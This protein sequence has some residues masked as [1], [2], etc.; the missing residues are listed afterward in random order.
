MEIIGKVRY[1]ENQIAKR[2][3]EGFRKFELIFSEELLT[4]KGIDKIKE[5]KNSL[6]IDF[7]SLHTPHVELNKIK[8]MDKKIE[9]VSDELDI[10]YIVL[11]SSKIKDFSPDFLELAKGRKLLENIL[12]LGPQKIINLM[13]SGFNF[14][15]DVAHFFVNASINK[16]NFLLELEKVL[17]K[18]SK[19]IKLVHF[20]DSDFKCD[21]L[22]FGEGLMN[23]DMSFKILSRYY[24]GYVVI[25][26]PIEYM[27]RDRDYLERL[28]KK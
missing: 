23:I 27:K 9:Y 2:Y 12:E 1:E 24:D 13:N 8:E 25:E 21:N 6:G 16:Y 10:K 3:D 14:C 22:G 17:K 11:H 18:G 5:I 4:Q 20:C 7:I 15:L 26:S 28:I 19:S